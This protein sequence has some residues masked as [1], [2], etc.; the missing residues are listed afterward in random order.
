MSEFDQIEENAVPAVEENAAPEENAVE[1]VEPTEEEKAAKKAELFAKQ[2]A[3][4]AKSWENQDVRAARMIRR[5]VL[6]TKPDGSSVSF[7]SVAKAFVELGLPLSKHYS[8]RKDLREIEGQQID[9]EYPEGV[10]YTFQDVAVSDKP[11]KAPKET[12]PAKLKEGDEGYVVPAPKAKKAKKE[13]VA[14]TANLVP[15]DAAPIDV[16]PSFD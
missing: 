16:E 14:P 9:F 3:G 2:S 7:G 13:K 15:E 4:T 8:L 5:G 6:V 10:R 11:A 12:K 1:P